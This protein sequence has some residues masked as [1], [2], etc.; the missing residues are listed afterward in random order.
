MYS[1]R[2]LNQHL[3][4][5]FSCQGKQAWMQSF[6]RCPS[7]NCLIISDKVIVYYYGPYS[8]TDLYSSILRV[9][10]EMPVDRFLMS[11]MIHVVVTLVALVV[12]VCDA[13]ICDA[14]FAV[15][16]FRPLLNLFSRGGACL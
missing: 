5:P 3:R 1:L 10:T 14:P 13:T 7:Y 15:D 8:R 16:P 11:S 2:E 6:G 9:Q 4:P 12:T